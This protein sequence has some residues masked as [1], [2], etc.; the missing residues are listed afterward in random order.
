MSG[1]TRFYH[2]HIPKT[3]GHYVRDKITSFLVEPLVAANI[4][5]IVAHSGWN[6]VTDTT[7]VFS[8][9]RDPIKR[10]VSHYCH[11]VKFFEN[12]PEKPTL[13]SFRKWCL[14]NY[15]FLANYQSKC[16]LY[17]Q[18]S[19]VPYFYRDDED[20]LA[21]DLKDKE[22][23][24]SRLSRVNLLMKDSDL[25]DEV[26]EKA[27]NTILTEVGAPHL[28]T[29]PPSSGHN[30]NEHSSALYSELKQSDVDF[31]AEMNRVDM[32]IYHDYPNYR[33]SW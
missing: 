32:E 15:S 13:E 29:K 2:L 31:I 12:N 24:Y 27:V 23:L 4:E 19:T 10:T 5:N 9:F 33:S 20:F 3:G 7:Y 11:H 1:F 21:I 28:A 6:Y 14:N 17:E 18:K 8:A 26:A 16:F 25:T 22:E 30:I